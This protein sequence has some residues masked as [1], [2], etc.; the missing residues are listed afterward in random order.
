MKDGK[1]ES[2]RKGAGNGRGSKPKGGVG[3]DQRR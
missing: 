3:G 1:L 2:M